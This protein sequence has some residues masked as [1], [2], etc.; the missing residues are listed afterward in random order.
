MT[1]LKK[2]VDFLVKYTRI[3]W[4]SVSIRWNFLSI[5]RQVNQFSRKMDQPF[6]LITQTQRSGGTLL[7]Q[8]FDGHPEIAVH[9]HQTNIGYPENN[10]WEHIAY[11]ENKFLKFFKLAEYSSYKLAREGF[12]KS[13]YGHRK[14]KFLFSLKIQKEIFFKFYKKGSGRELLNAYFTSYFNAWLN[15]RF[16]YEDAK[17]ICGFQTNI[18]TEADGENC[19]WNY[20]P[21]GYIISIVRSPRNWCASV[22]KF[23]KK[24]SENTIQAEMLVWKK[25]VEG[26]IKEKAARPDRVIVINFDD[27]IVNTENVVRLLSE[28]LDIS[29]SPT[30]LTPTFN[31]EHVDSNSSHKVVRGKVDKNVL[32]R[33]DELSL[34]EVEY[35]NRECTPLFEKCLNDCI[36]K[37]EGV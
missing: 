17:Y 18:I 27:L 7:S 35:I 6:V 10:Q 34:E 20:Y 30:M 19:F 24:L 15:C 13:I 3:L 21:D 12:S 32:K 25:N 4:G 14:N 36:E 9:P 33:D 31:L 1:P 5:K 29:Y 26:I 8:L 23:N 37:V 2:T 16:I 28:R 22:R 11:S